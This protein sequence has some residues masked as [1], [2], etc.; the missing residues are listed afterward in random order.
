MCGI[1]G[2]IRKINSTGAV[3]SDVKPMIKFMKTAFNYSQ[4]RGTHSTGLIKVD[5]GYRKTAY[6]FKQTGGP[7]EDS[8]RV[9]IVK[10][11]VPAAKFLE[12][13]RVV[14]LFATAHKFTSS[15]IG[16]TRNASSATPY[17][18]KNNHP[19]VCGSIIG[20]HNGHISNWGQVAHQFDLKLN[21]RCDSEVI[22]ALIDKL[23]NEHGATFKEA[24]NTACEH[25]DG[26]YACVVL[27]SKD[28]L[29]YGVFRKGAPLFFR[30]RSATSTLFFASTHEIL[31]SA[32]ME[33][34]VEG[35]ANSKYYLD[36]GE[37]YLP[38]G[39]G[40]ILNGGP[41]GDTYSY[42]DDWVKKVTPFKLK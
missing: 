41:S 6:E 37:I 26:S 1:L 7:E 16:H 24:I 36:S 21:S 29:K 32:Y 3:G 27:D 19:H 30:Y 5:S 31:S 22:F 20:V 10:E 17:N 33:A 42:G 8:A 34:G 9:A 2:A 28:P 18:N 13:Q 40:Y 35:G 11:P 4:I 14:H 25:L 23:T 12:D 15:Y 38:S 39:Y